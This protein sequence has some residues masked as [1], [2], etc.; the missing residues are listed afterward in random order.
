M[1]PSRHR[2]E[3]C[4]TA[5]RPGPRRRAWIWAACFALA[6]CDDPEAPAPAPVRP[7]KLMEV[8]STENV[9]TVSLPALI[10]ASATTELGFQVPG[11]VAAI[12]VQ[13]GRRVAKD[14]E[15]ARLDRRELESEL[16]TAK[17]N[18]E[19][20]EADFQRA[21]RLIVEGAISQAVHKQRQTRR[22]VTAAALDTARKHL[23]DSVLRAPFAGI[24][25]AVHIEA[26][27]NVAPQQA[28]ATVQ[29]TGVMEAV[30]QMPATLLAHF[31]HVKPLETMVVLD[32]APETPVPAEYRSIVAR[33]DSAR[34]TFEAHF[35]FTPPGD[36]IVLPGMTGVVRATLAVVGET[37]IAVPVEAILGEAAA[38]YVWV[39]DTASMTVSKREV[40]LGAGV[41]RTLPV[42]AG[43][44]AGE[45]IVAAG[46]AHLHEGMRVRRYRP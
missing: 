24:V 2:P 38:R 17:A 30:V 29:S 20:A 34:Q 25:A 16:A 42:I 19:A 43:L 31:N 9:K 5:S 12:A 13:E 26:F 32:A 36:L 11:L 37:E 45:T 46:V 35:T 40:T 33:A 15:I 44:A 8:A 27:Q 39:V 21:E 14:D 7:A 23:D 41:G 1:V 10:E 28:V 18:H 4:I 3:T 22:D 6:G